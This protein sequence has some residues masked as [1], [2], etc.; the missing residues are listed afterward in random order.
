MWKAFISRHYDIYD[1]KTFILF[2]ETNDKKLQQ[3]KKFLNSLALKFKMWNIFLLSRMIKND[4]LTVL[5]A[6]TF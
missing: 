3:H 5:Q 2:G 1:I 6:E 4:L